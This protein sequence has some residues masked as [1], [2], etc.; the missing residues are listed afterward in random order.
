MSDSPLPRSR[1]SSVILYADIATPRATAVS[2]RVRNLSATGA[3]VDNA[4]G[5]VEGDRV[6][7]AMGV[8]APLDARVIWAKPTLAGLRFA[9]EVDLA[10]AR[11]PRKTGQTVA[12]GWIGRLDD[13]YRR[14]S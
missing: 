13:P 2:C 9:S 12:A 14:R 5:L 8:L 6:R 4:A 3:C 11:A 1:R 10:A 7:V